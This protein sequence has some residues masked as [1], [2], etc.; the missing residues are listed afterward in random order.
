MAHTPPPITSA[1]NARIV[2]LRKLEQRKHRERQGRFFAEG[3]QALHMALDAGHQ[4]LELFYCEAL[5]AGPEAP[6]LLARAQ[7]LGCPATPLAEPVLRSL[8][9][10]TAPQGLVGVFPLLWR[11]LSD[12][13]VASGDLVVV[14]D[15]LNDPGN[16]GTI[17]RTADAVGA[18]AVALAPPCVDPFDPK[19]VRAT[20]GSLFN[21]P[22]VQAPD[23]AALFAALKGAGLRI[24]GADAHQG[25]PWDEAIWPGGVAL[26]L[27]NEA[28][29][30][31]E[32]LLPAIDA[33]ASLPMVGQAESLNVAVAGGVLM[34]AWLRA[35]WGAR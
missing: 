32:D 26:V 16:L 11:Q 28:Q 22:L 10:R 8:S 34:Y 1:R 30:L 20:M 25:R 7:A 31:S 35:N 2:A 3:L 4:P 27:G 14:V 9:D 18:A 29:G 21:V 33:W 15:R 24:I 19:T 13:G 12:L 5:F 6:A 17:I 23:P